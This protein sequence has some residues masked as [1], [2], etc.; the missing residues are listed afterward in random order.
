[1]NA[2]TADLGEPTKLPAEFNR[3]INSLSKKSGI[4][5]K[6]IE[7]IY[8]KKVDELAA[9]ARI[10]TYGGVLAMRDTRAI[11]QHNDLKRGF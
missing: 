2:C 11:L 9:H 6:T 8:L 4:P 5:T 10:Q 3:I 7:E 1:M